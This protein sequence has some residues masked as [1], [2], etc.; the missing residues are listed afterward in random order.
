MKTKLYVG[1]DLIGRFTCDGRKYTVTQKIAR[2]IKKYLVY[3]F[4]IVIMA[5][6]VTGGIFIAKATLT[7]VT[8]YA[9]RVIEVPIETIAPV[10]EKIAKCESG[11]NH[12]KNGQVIFN[13]NSDGS[14]DIGYYQ[15]NSIHNKQA[16]KLGYDLTKESDNKAYAMYLY[17]TQGTEPWYASKS[18]W[19]K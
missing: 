4:I 17:K 14:V 15:I 6:L 16:T 19:N 7:P 11:N 2:A 9:D 8:A 1:R 13:S 12:Y 18:C 10:M 5:W 3:S